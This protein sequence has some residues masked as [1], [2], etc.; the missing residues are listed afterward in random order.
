MESV[1]ST[2]SSEDD[3]H[4]KHQLT[5][6][7]QYDMD[8]L[9][10]MPRWVYQ[11]IMLSIIVTATVVIAAGS[12]TQMVIQVAQVFNGCLLPFFSCCLLLCLNDLQFM[13]NNPQKW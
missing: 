9:K 1:S 13:G 8:N 4:A 12:D 11:F 6:R 2:S 3:G 5:T 10:T 7:Q